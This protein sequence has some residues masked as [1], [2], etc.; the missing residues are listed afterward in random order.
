MSA[1]AACPSMHPSATRSNPTDTTWDSFLAPRK[2]EARFKREVSA[3]HA[4][5][6]DCSDYRKH[7]SPWPTTAD[8]GVQTEVADEDDM[9]SI[10]LGDGL[11]DDTLI[12]AGEGIGTP[13]LVESR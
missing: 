7:F 4:K 9:V 10:D 6:C 8:A 2:R 12:E 1:A 3:L 13:A 5:F 11:S